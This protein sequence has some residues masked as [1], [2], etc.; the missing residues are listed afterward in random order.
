MSG[1]GLQ[2][3][4][5]KDAGSYLQI[6]HQCACSPARASN[7]LPTAI[8]AKYLCQLLL[9]KF[10]L[11]ESTGYLLFISTAEL[12]DRLKAPWTS[13]PAPHRL[14]TQPHRPAPLCSCCSCGS[15]PPPHHANPSSSNHR[16]INLLCSWRSFLWLPKRSA[17]FWYQHQ[18]WEQEKDSRGTG[19]LCL[20]ATGH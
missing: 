6:N 20:T 18:K 1:K 7:K 3:S 11:K 16:K 13:P 12:M 10:R 19:L 2:Y 17:G 5:K 15:C 8:T 9:L 4:G 14:C